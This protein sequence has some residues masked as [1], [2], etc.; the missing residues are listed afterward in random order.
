VGVDDDRGGE[1]TVQA[2]RKAPD[3]Q[4]RPHESPKGVCRPLLSR[5]SNS[6]AD[7]TVLITWM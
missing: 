7:P 5:L 2:L 3:A 1:E 4:K 6:L